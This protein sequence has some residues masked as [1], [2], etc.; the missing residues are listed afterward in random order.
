MNQNQTAF[1]GWSVFLLLIAMKP[2]HAAQPPEGGPAQQHSTIHV[3]E[4]L[5]A[6]KY[7]Y[8]Y[9]L[10]AADLDGDGD[11][12]LTSQNVVGGEINL[13]SMWWFE[14]DGQGQ[15][16]RRLIH[17]DDQDI[18]WFERHSVGDIDGD[19]RLDV[20]VV[21]NK[22]GRLVWFA[23]NAHPADGPWQRRVITTQSPRVYDVI[24]ADLDGDGDL[25]AADAGYANNQNC[26]YENPGPKGRDHEWKRRLVGEKMSEAR[27]IGSGDFNGDGRVDLFASA[28]GAANIPPDTTDPRQHGSSIVWYENSGRPTDEPW[29][30]HIISDTDRAPI[31][32]HPADMDGDGDLDVVMAHGMRQELLPPARHDVAWYENVGQPGRGQQWRRHAIS[33]LAYAFEA[34]AIDM[35]NDH[36]MDVVASAW[37]RGDRIV[38]F[39]NSGDPRVRWTPHVVTADFKSVNQVIAADLNGDGRPDLAATADSGSSRVVGAQELRWWRND[40]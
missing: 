3:S 35:D 24:L 29:K 17:K 7:D 22:F 4:H 37:A 33:P 9:G 21:D 26:W 34:I 20:A 31:H 11:L 16:Q 36:D 19:G 12:D 1:R 8:A 38:W 10:A 23:N 5:I 25:D 32:G 6:G 13:S 39:E 28:V 2:L 14:N 40:K 27:S 18:G 30:K 15:F